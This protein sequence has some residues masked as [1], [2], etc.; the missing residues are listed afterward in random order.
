[1]FSLFPSVRT[2]SFQ[3]LA[4][5]SLLII[6]TRHASRLTRHFSFHPSTSQH[7]NASIMPRCGNLY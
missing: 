4:P 6:A 2:P 5:C 1:L 3:L 7:L